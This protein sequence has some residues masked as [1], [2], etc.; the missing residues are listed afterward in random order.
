M[1]ASGRQAFVYVQVTLLFLLWG[2]VTSIND[3]LVP[4][5]RSIFS[6]G[7]TEALLTQF[8]FFLAYGVAS[9]PAA[10]L[11]ARM[12]PARS[13]ILALGIMIV[14]CC[15]MLLATRLFS[16]PVA[17]T[18]LFVLAAGITL[19]QVAANPLVA[20]LG[21][22]RTAH[23]RLTLSQAFNSLGTLVA[24][25]IAASVLLS[26]GVF[27]G[28]VASSADVAVSLRRIDTAY[29]FIAFVLTTFA[30]LTLANRRAVDAAAEADNG[31]SSVR[32]AARDR[33]ALL[34]A[35]AIFLYVGAE[36]S[37]GS[38]LVNFLEQ[39]DILGVTAERAGHLLAL[40]WG[41]AMIGRF[42]GSAI[43][44]RLKAD[45]LLAAAAFAAATLS[46]AVTLLSGPIAAVAALSIG[47]FNS[48]MFP[49][50]FT[51]TLNRSQASSS[52]T[53]GLL[54]V[55]IVGG[56]FVPLACGITAASIGLS[57]AFVVPA[58][59]YVAICLFARAAGRTDVPT[60]GPMTGA[61]EL[62]A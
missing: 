4:A 50:I 20:S 51:L 12:A 43:L 16:Y 18:A 46:A 15:L 39:R 32:E 48:V 19:L 49:V 55:A 30:C 33:W 21:P 26:G 42:A 13:I 61:P 59:C 27:S 40:Y 5:M 34:G 60:R 10:G 44:T 1:E 25:P 28:S 24:P 6:L 58:V 54:C 53:S 3:I 47:L 11:V 31:R 36:V 52:A 23:F 37:V 2:A 45:R 7:M 57:R 38:V 41:G 35:V 17:L 62:A 56:A 22:P 8:A 9:L 14:A 29:I